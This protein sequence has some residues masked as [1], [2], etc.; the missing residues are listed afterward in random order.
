MI[1]LK[2]YLTEG[3]LDVDDNLEKDYI[4]TKIEDFINKNYKVT[5]KLKINLIKDKYIVN[6]NKRVEEKNNNI[7][8]LTNGFFEWGE[9][10]GLFNCSYCN[11]LQSLEGAPKKVGG[12]FD[13]SYCKS[14]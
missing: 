5:G 9:V 13:C 8:S 1:S 11:S 14:L 4:K 10:D 6:C 7:K 2:E 12:Y 3:I